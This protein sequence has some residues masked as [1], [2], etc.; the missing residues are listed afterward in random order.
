MISGAQITPVST[1]SID[2]ILDL[3][4]L[5][6]VYGYSLAIGG[7]LFY[8]L[9]LVKSAI[10]L[11][12][13]LTENHW[14]YWSSGKTTVAAPVSLTLE[15]DLATVTGTATS[16]LP[17]AGEY[18]TITGAT[19]TSFNGTF[20][21]ASATATNFTYTVIIAA[22]LLDSYGNILVTEKGD[23]LLEEIPPTAGVI[24]GSCQMSISFNSYFTAVASAGNNLLLDVSSGA[25][26]KLDTGTYSD[27]TGPIDF[28]IVTKNLSPGGTSTLT[29]ITSAEVRGDKVLTTGYLRYS[30]TDYETWASFRALSMQSPRA[31]TLRLGATRRRAFHFR[32]VD[33][34]PL[35]VEELLIGIGG[36]DVAAQPTGG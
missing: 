5:S 19:N 27:H 14:T 21:V 12:Y 13:N 23:A 28:N 20:L 26:E 18:V 9:S 29:R 6:G 22:Y 1:P 7:R 25:V 11:C 32:H 35:R 2:S 8:L 36:A 34:T 33:D 16:T 31:R 15:S 30:D 17:T 24:A 10:T 3:D 4:D